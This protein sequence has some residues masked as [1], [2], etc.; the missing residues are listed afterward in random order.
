M[1]LSCDNSFECDDC[2]VIDTNCFENLGLT[3][4]AL[5]VYFD[6]GEPDRCDKCFKKWIT[7]NDEDIQEIV[8]MMNEDD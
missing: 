3:Q 5:S 6:A 2:N 1:S 4:H 7:S 8:Q